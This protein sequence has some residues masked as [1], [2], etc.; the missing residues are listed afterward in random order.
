MKP[1]SW[2]SQSTQHLLM[3]AASP[4]IFPTWLTPSIWAKLASSTCI[5]MAARAIQVLSSVAILH[6]TG[7]ALAAQ[8]RFESYAGTTPSCKQ[9]RQYHVVAGCH[10][11]SR[12]HNHKAIRL[13][14]SRITQSK[15]FFIQKELGQLLLA[16]KVW[17][18]FCS[19]E[20][21]VLIAPTLCY[22]KATNVSP[23]GLYSHQQ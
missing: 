1:S 5:L 21:N 10:K 13:Q 14:H 11:D 19:I 18:H 3:P 9:H 22:S 15:R 20:V 2:H 23:S 17:P 4:Q 16:G 7:K 12:K 6:V 8:S